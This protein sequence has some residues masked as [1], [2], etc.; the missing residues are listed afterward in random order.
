MKS[1]YVFLLIEDNEIDQLIMTQLFKKVLNVSGVNIAN[2]GKEGI[3]WLLS[4]REKFSQSLIILLDIQ[5]PIMNGP[6]FLVEYEK[7][8]D[9]LK[10]ETQI[11]MLSSSLDGDEIKRVKGNIHV[12]DFL[13]KPIR[14]KEFSKILYAN[15]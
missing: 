15:L 12:S 1:K 6:Q 13:S 2:N 8:A 14:I 7:L 5:M 10:R 3:Q 11:F 4:N 9:S